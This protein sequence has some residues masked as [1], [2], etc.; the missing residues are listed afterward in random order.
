M[1]AREAVQR[2]YWRIMHYWGLVLGD[3]RDESI[4]GYKVQSG[5]LG[6]SPSNAKK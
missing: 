3:R 2:L 1:K 5:V 4:P 6:A